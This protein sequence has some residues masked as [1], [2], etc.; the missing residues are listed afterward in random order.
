MVEMV[1]F[2][3]FRR[4]RDAAGVRRLYALA[5]LPFTESALSAPIRSGKTRRSLD[6]RRLWIWDE[7]SAS[8]AFRANNAISCDC[9]SALTTSGLR[10]L[11]RFVKLRRLLGFRK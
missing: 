8:F 9:R 6:R 2:R 5:G 11:R 7:A 10:M 4:R 3:R 1:Q